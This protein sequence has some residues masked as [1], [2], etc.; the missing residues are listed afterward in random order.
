MRRILG[1]IKSKNPSMNKKINTGKDIFSMLS[2]LLEIGDIDIR[3]RA[4]NAT[5]ANV[6]NAYGDVYFD[7]SNWDYVFE[8]TGRS[9]NRKIILQNTNTTIQIAIFNNKTNEMLL[10]ISNIGLDSTTSFI[11]RNAG[12][13]EDFD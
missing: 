9:Q 4:V 11:M 10:D 1:L 3:S 6:Y 8:Q 12:S 2:T 5:V 7:F 13:V